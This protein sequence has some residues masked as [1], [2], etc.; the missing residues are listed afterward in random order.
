MT[1][2]KPMNEL[3][4]LPGLD[5]LKALAICMVLSL[6]VP[7]WYTRFIANPTGVTYLSYAARLLC[8][9][10]PIFL[11]VNGFLMAGSKH[12]SIEGHLRRTGKLIALLLVWGVILTV[13][14]ALSHG[15][16]SALSASY[17]LEHVLVTKLG[18]E[19]TGVLW[20]LQY[21]AAAYLIW[22]ILMYVYEREFR[23]YGYFFGVVAFFRLGVDTLGLIRDYLNVWTDTTMLDEAITFIGRFSPL[24]YATYLYYLM[25][26]GIIWHYKDRIL[27]AAGKWI[28]A[29]LAAWGVSCL[30]GYSLSLLRGKVYTPDFNYDSIFMTVMVVGMMAAAIRYTGRDRWWER[31]LCCL[32]QHTLG[33][34]LCHYLLIFAV[35]RF[36]VRE[37]FLQR[38]AAYLV[39]LAGSWALAWILKKI[40]GVRWLV[41]L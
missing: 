41:T 33:I 11:V 29:A 24:G 12:W 6:H 8:E 34:Y 39:V 18:S 4:R 23:L 19:Y 36:F 22:P 40:P 31:V 30:Y 25:L 15:D 17:V 35:N 26:G 14:G 37:R 13:A 3:R 28:G 10:V 5:L 32:G 1:N 2:R 9:G 7:L 20:Y 21:L 27:E 16:M 38:L